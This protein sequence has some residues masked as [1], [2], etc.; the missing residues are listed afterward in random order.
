M[1]HMIARS[2]PKCSIIIRAY[3]EEKHI[4][5]LLA[6]IMKQ[7]VKQIEIILVDSGST[8]ATIAIASRYP[9]NV[10]TIKPEEFTFGRSLN[11]GIAQASSEFI[12]I[13]SAHVYP[14]YPDWLEQLLLPF[15]DPQV[16]LVY[17]KQ[18]G[19]SSTKYSE[20]Q[21]FAK[22]FPEK[23]V[24][25]QRHPFCNNANA[26]IRRTLWSQRPYDE[27][28]PGLE[29]LSWAMWAVSQGYFLAYSAE[30]EV[31][32]IHNE[33]GSQIYNR[34]RREA[35]A[36]KIIRPQER[37][38]FR[39]FIRLYFSNTFSDCWHA[40]HQHSLFKELWSIL[41]FRFWQF[42]GTYRGFALSGP[43]TG[44]LKQIF[45]YPRGLRPTRVTHRREIEPIDY[46]Y[47]DSE[48]TSSS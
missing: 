42:W 41:R 28:L 30:A 29:D 46:L 25:R 39:D 48:K 36:L 9:V 20:H 1:V 35:M 22:I 10:V 2:I 18:R 38:Y 34:F 6:G 37:F 27:A 32:H 26:A 23:S 14:V 12:V 40:F 21:H 7:T 4:G 16:T 44:E 3:N 15:T 31:I 11:Y 43:L 5:R 45:Y 8:D 19:N 47:G 33:T 17:G 13:V 24:P